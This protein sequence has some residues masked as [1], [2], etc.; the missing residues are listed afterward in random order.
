MPMLDAAL[1]VFF[2]VVGPGEAE[3]LRPC[4]REGRAAS[5]RSRSNLA[6]MVKLSWWTKRRR[7]AR[8]GP[9]TAWRLTPVR[10]PRDD[11]SETRE[12]VSDPGWDVGGTKCNLA[13]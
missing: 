1:R 6:T 10:Y 9:S 11:T 12:K 8:S 2:L 5:L 7:T 4:W 3:T 13:L